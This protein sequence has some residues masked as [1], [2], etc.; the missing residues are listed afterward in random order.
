MRASQDCQGRAI[1]K[2]AIRQCREPDTQFR[3]WREYAR[4]VRFRARFAVC[5]CGGTFLD[6]LVDAIEVLQF[7]HDVWPSAQ[8]VGK[9]TDSFVAGGQ[10]ASIE[11]PGIRGD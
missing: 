9:P 7:G 8:Y 3:R 1:A 5:P 2:G 6:D 11:N 10:A 4:C